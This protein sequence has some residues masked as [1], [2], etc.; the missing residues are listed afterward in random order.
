MSALFRWPLLQFHLMPYHNFYRPVQPNPGLWAS[1]GLPFCLGVVLMLVDLYLI[2]GIFALPLLLL[3]VLIYL[4]LRV[5]P[6]IVTLWALIYA[7]AIY[8]FVLLNVTEAVTNPVYK[9][10]LR[11]AVFL[12]GGTG[13]VMMA[14]FR[15]RLQ[16]GHEALFRIIAALPL[17]VIV[18]DIS[19]NILL[20]NEQAKQ[21]LKN[22]VGPS[23]DPSYFG[24]FMDPKD[25]GRSI[26]QYIGYFDP[27]HVGTVNTLLRA[28]GEPQLF[29]H[30]SITTVMVDGHRYAITMVERIEHEAEA[31][32]VGSH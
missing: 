22:H 13:A 9:P 18:S 27:S 21:V 17:A 30:S 24:L 23:T 1:A 32:L 29:L 28:Q 16:A 5:P 15:Q 6:R 7:A 12:T 10:Y 20:L 11:T 31:T 26:A 3:L 2:K 4:S 14:A 8:L 25:H 19:G